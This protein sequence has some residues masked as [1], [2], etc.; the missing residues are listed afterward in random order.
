MSVKIEYQGFHSPQAGGLAGELKLLVG[1]PVMLT[2]NIAVEL[3]LTNGNMG[4]EN[5]K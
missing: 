2:K 4:T 5:I 1:M 3:G